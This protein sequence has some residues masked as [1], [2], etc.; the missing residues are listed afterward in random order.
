MEVRRL[1]EEASEPRKK[2]SKRGIAGG[3]IGEVKG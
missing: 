1:E 2:G 3:Q